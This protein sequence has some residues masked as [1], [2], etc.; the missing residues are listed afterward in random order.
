MNSWFANPVIILPTKDYAK[1][2]LN[3]RYLNSI[4]DTTNSRWSI[5]PLSALMTRK[6]A[7]VFTNS[8]LSPVYNQVLLTEDRLKVT[9]FI[10]GCRQYTY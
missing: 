5:E 6:T 10:V 2:I 7:T 9:S 8:D 3:A 4:T 1:L